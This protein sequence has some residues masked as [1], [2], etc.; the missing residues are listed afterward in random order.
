MVFL[1]TLLLILLALRPYSDGHLT[2]IR[3]NKVPQDRP[4]AQSGQGDRPPAQVTKVFWCCFDQL[5]DNSLPFAYPTFIEMS[6]QVLVL[7]KD[8]HKLQKHIYITIFGTHLSK[9][10]FPY[11]NCIL[12]NGFF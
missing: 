10:I 8:L 9:P 12:Q 11:T 1:V 4:T 3:N 6:Q 5:R 7:P 2:I